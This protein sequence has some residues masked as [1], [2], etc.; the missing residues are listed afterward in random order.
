V[1]DVTRIQTTLLLALALLF[2][3]ASV[4][5][6]ETNT[7]KTTTRTKT[8]TVAFKVK[9]NK[10]GAPAKL[11]GIK[12]SD[13]KTECIGEDDLK[14][15]PTLS[16]SLGDIKVR[17]VRG[18]HRFLKSQTIAGRTWTF[19]GILNGKGRTLIK[20]QLNPQF[21]QDGRDCNR[22]G[23]ADLKPATRK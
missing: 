16:A 14:P 13:F 23:S 11:T 1:G 21:R 22:L 15:G 10:A 9:T 6:A 17:L 2:V 20:G 3:P 5:A 4:A 19:S 12:V 8:G 18:H 7:F